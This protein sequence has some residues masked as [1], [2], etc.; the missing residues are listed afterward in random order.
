MANIDYQ[1][2]AHRYLSARFKDLETFTKEEF[3][4]ATGWSESAFKT[5]WSKQLKWLLETTDSELYRVRGTFARYLNITDFRAHLSQVKGHA[6]EYEYQEYEKV[7]VY[8]FY[9]PLAHEIA[10]RMTLDS[11]FYEDVIIPR[12]KRIDA[13][14]LTQHIPPEKLFGDAGAVDRARL[15]VDRKF[16]GYS[17]YHVSGRFRADSLCTQGARPFACV[18]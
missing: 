14:S 7:I 1:E 8:E 16:G 6:N 4:I 12:L 11:L 9:M 17:I 18:L 10:L 3:Q 2:R 13:Q 5:Y 15:F